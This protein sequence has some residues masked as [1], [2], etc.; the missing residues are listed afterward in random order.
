MTSNRLGLFA[1]LMVAVSLISA[2]CDAKKEP[3][4]DAA[5]GSTAAPHD[6]AGTAPHSHDST[7]ATVP[8]AAPVASDV[9]TY[10]FHGTPTRIDEA[11]GMITINH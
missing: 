9:K 7:G 4:A 3:A 6:D 1:I 10:T 11:S 5:A 8:A 2:G